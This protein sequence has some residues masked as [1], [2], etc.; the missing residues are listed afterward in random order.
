MKSNFYTYLIFLQ[1]ILLALFSSCSNVTAEK[2]NLSF[3][4]AI[5]VKQNINEF[6][7]VKFDSFENLNL[8]FFRGNLWIKLNVKN[9]ENKNKSLM[10]ISN[11]RFNRNYLFYK[12]DSLTNLAKV[13]NPITNNLIEDQRTFNNPNPNLKIDLEP[14]EKATYLII[15]ESDGRT[16]DATPKI[17]TI[18]NYFDYV[19]NETL[20]NIIFYG[21][22]LCLLLINLYQWN[23]YRQN[24]Y[25]Y[26][27][28]YIVSTI[29][30]YLGIEGYFYSFRVEQIIIDHFIFI[31]VK[32]WALSLIMYTSKFLEIQLV[33]PRYYQFIKI[34]LVVVLGGTLLYQLVFYDSSIAHLHYFENLLSALW[35]TL[36]AGIVMFSVKKKRLELKYYL[37][38]LATFIVFTLIGLVN[39]HLQILPVNSFTFVKIGALVELIGFTYFMTLLIKKKLQ[40]TE[41]LEGELLEN[42]K[43]LLSAS[44]EIA[45]KDKIIST[46]TKIEK[47]DLISIFKIV[48]NTLSTEIKWDDFKIK[49]ADLNSD[50]LNQLLAIHPDLSKSEIRLLT[51]IKIGYSQKE[52]AIILNITPDSVKKARTRAKKKLHL[53]PDVMLSH[54]LNSL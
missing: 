9:I 53:P 4:A 25:F 41:I 37:I 42:R 18:E 30:V 33:A 27:V 8:G 48:E 44:E 6:N 34:V 50:F 51:L 49:L 23:I 22:I 2:K 46:K 17:L 43:Q 28:F 47:T 39:V 14:Y 16:K 10:F 21:I 15:S 24:I 36:I 3:T 52:I 11:D 20:W 32:L 13:V 12:I 31:C 19:H 54:H 35:L 7:K 1:A 26:Y 40:K 45:K 5:N 38:P 29:F